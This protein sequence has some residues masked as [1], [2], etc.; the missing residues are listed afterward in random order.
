MSYVKHNIHFLTW[1]PHPLQYL[2]SCLR[3]FY[4]ITC[5]IVESLMYSKVDTSVHTTLGTLLSDTGMLIGIYSLRGHTFCT[6]DCPRHVPLMEFI[7][8]EPWSLWGNNGLGCTLFYIEGGVFIVNAAMP[9]IREVSIFGLLYY[10]IWLNLEKNQ[11]AQLMWDSLS[12]SSLEIMT[13]FCAVWTLLSSL[14][15]SQIVKLTSLTSF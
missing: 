7:S 8:H 14:E 12:C 11:C 5:G 13:L 15:A 4:S 9:L 2:L 10:L 1:C 6:A 3:F